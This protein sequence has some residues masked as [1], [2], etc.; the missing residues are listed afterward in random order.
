MFSVFAEIFPAKHGGS[1]NARGAVMPALQ[2]S[3]PLV[4][5][6]QH[7]G[8]YGLRKRQQES[9]VG[10][11]GIDTGRQVVG[12]QSAFKH[13]HQRTHTVRLQHASQLRITAGPADLIQL[14]AT[15]RQIETSFL[16]C[17]EEG[18]LQ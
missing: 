9:V 8:P 4:A 11:V 1:E 12:Q 14:Q 7:I 6:H 2:Q 3:G 17:N 18:V 10:I 16:P 13:I 5:R 15:T